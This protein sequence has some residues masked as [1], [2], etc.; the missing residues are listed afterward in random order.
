[1]GRSLAR[2]G[3]R[4]GSGERKAESGDRPGRAGGRGDRRRLLLTDNGK[5]TGRQLP[6]HR[7]R[8]SLACNGEYSPHP[9]SP[10]LHDTEPVTFTHTLAEATWASGFFQPLPVCMCIIYILFCELWNYKSQRVL[11][12]S[13][14]MCGVWCHAGICSSPTDGAQQVPAAQSLRPPPLLYKAC[15]ARRIFRCP[16]HCGVPAL[17][18]TCLSAG[19]SCE[20]NKAGE[21][22]RRGQG[23][24]CLD[25]WGWK[26]RLV[27]PRLLLQ[28]SESMACWGAGTAAG[29]DPDS[30]QGSAPALG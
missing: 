20:P 22:V 6:A 8:R 16:G 12:I 1:M 7:K 23:A 10:A 27:Y 13:S 5:E 2:Q 18:G 11:P 17:E 28:N 19:N 4:G 15:G 14:C 26:E 3:E 24:A 9:V 25:N 21:S 29:S 30:S